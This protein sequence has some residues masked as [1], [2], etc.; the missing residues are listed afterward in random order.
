M[1]PARKDEMDYLPFK[2]TRKR[3]TVYI[4]IHN[5]KTQVNPVELQ[6]QFNWVSDGESGGREIWYNTD[7]ICLVLF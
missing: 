6:I 4:Y 7:E 2:S 3:D 5:E 1:R